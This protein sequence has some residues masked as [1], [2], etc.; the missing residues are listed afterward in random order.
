M[1]DEKPKNKRLEIVDGQCRQ[2]PARWRKALK[3][4][5]KKGL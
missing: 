2:D 4:T 1:K 3:K 5:K